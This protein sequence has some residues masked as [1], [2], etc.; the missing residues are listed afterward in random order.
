MRNIVKVGAFVIMIAVLVAAL[1]NI[2]LSQ[3][4]KFV[5]SFNSTCTIESG[6]AKSGT[7]VILKSG[8]VL[9][10]AHVVDLNMNG[11]ISNRERNCTAIFRH[12]N[13]YK[14]R[15]LYLGDQDFAILEIDDGF[16]S[17]SSAVPSY[18]T[19]NLGDEVY[20]IGAMAG[21]KP[22]ISTGR[23]STP[24][25]NSGRT[26]CAVHGGNS[27]GGVF[28]NDGEQIGVIVAVGMKREYDTARFPILS[29]DGVQIITA[30]IARKTEVNNVSLYL[31]TEN[32]RGELVAKNLG[33]L[34]DV[35]PQPSLLDYATDRYFIDVFMVVLQLYVF[36]AFVIYVR[37]HAFR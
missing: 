3:P 28:A 33:F 14:A 31:P 22:H 21:H 32:I 36:L 27:G 35:Q 18:K 13:R 5:N 10:A 20:T 11:R 16:F 1:F 34:L 24:D 29:D 17:K 26:S 4:D 30:T 37:H 2:Y 6:F 19:P 9:T 12:G 7:G 23:V 25:M 8:Y 15:V